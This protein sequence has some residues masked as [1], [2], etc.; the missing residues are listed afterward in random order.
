MIALIPIIGP[1]AALMLSPT[2]LA[3]AWSP[4]VAVLIAALF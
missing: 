2:V 1:V 4:A 3:M